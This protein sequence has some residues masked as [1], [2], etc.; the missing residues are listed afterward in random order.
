VAAPTALELLPSFRRHLAAENMAPRTA[1]AYTEGVTRLHE[2]LTAA[3]MPTEVAKITRDHVEAFL[4]DPA[5][6]AEG[7]QRPEPVRKHSSVLSLADG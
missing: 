2:F 3:G 4:A 5:G 1:Q 6:P 7:L